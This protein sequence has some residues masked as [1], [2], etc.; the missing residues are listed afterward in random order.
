MTDVTYE[1]RDQIMHVL[2][3]GEDTLNS[4]TPHTIA[5]LNTMIE[6]AEKDH[7]LRAVVIRGAGRKAFCVGMDIT[8]LADCFGDP[9]GVFVP[10]LESYHATLLRLE[11]LPVPVVAQVDGLARA[12][13]FEL[14]LACDIVIAA[15]DAKVGDV[16]VSFGVPP[17]AGASQRAVRKL[18]DQRAKALM[19]TPTWLDGPAMVQWGLALA[20]HPYEE[21]DA[22]VEAFVGSMR[23]QSRPVMAITKHLLTDARERGFRE[24]LD[25]ELAL[26]KR[27]LAE[28]PDH[29]EGFTAFVERR[30]PFWGDADVSGLR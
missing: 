1:V 30:E 9:A 28:V 18:G 2:L 5:G 11:S 15:E 16:H 25:H 8:F 27:L 24:G 17:G 19:L 21:L 14:I 10:F 4:L 6:A 29:A 23:G 13:G 12:G 3:D 22:A 26:F 7:S 20:S